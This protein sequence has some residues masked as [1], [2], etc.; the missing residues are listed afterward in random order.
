[1][2]AHSHLLRQKVALLR[3]QLRAASARFWQQARLRDFFPEFLIATHQY[4]RASVPLLETAAETCAALAGSDPIAARLASYYSAHAAEE[5]GHDQWLLEDLGHMGVAAGDVLRQ[6]PPAS[7]AALAGAQYFWIRHA[8]PVALLGYMTVLEQPPSEKH[9]ESVQ[10]RT[11]LP[12][13]AFRTLREHARLDHGHGAE[14]DA[15]I[16]S[17]PLDREK[18][19]LVGLSAI[20]TVAGLI[21]WYDELLEHCRGMQPV[22]RRGA[23]SRP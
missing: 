10:R 5:R 16:D 14:M 13:P 20:S 21:R 2:C 4:V 23:Q 6:V 19:E 18:I 7:V 11:K 8:H 17:L 3:P 1:M 12:A 22:R 15:L 9:L